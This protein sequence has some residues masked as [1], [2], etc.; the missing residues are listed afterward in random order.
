MEELARPSEYKGHLIKGVGDPSHKSSLLPTE[1]GEKLDPKYP[2]M[3]DVQK[4]YGTCEGCQAPS[5]G[6]RWETTSLA[7]TIMPA[8]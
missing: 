7:V 5:I 1:D 8:N 6:M 2:N 3:K 4:K